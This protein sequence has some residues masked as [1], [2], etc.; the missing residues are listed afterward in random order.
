M[1]WCP[2]CGNENVGK[3]V[4]H[5]K[6]GPAWMLLLCIMVFILCLVLSFV[7]PD[8][9]FVPGFL[10]IVGVVICFKSF[11]AEIYH[12]NSCGKEFKRVKY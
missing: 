5:H 4:V 1:P 3:T 11:N 7:N 12:C 2:K 8:A 9:I 10:W 6:H